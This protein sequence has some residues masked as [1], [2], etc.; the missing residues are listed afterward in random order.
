MGG[1]LSEAAGVFGS[2]PLYKMLGYFSIIGL[3]RLH[4]LLGDY[5]LALD[6]MSNIDLMQRV[7]RFPRFPPL[8]VSRFLIVFALIFFFRVCSPGS[9]P[10][11][12]PPST[13]LDFAT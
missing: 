2:R 7:G 10:A 1:Y 8:I 4:C 11:T 3:L 6:V 9:P 5:Y 12:L 13:M